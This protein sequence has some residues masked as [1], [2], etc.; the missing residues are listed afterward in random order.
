MST[1]LS[2]STP[3]I[4]LE[5]DELLFAIPGAPNENSGRFHAR[6]ALWWLVASFIRYWWIYHERSRPAS[7]GIAA[8]LVLFTLV[9]LVYTPWR[10]YLLSSEGMTPMEIPPW[11]AQLVYLIFMLMPFGA[12]L[13]DALSHATISDMLYVVWCAM[14]HHNAHS[15]TGFKSKAI[16]STGLA[17]G[18]YAI[19]YGHKALPRRSWLP[20]YQRAGLW[21][22]WITL[23]FAVW[24]REWLIAYVAWLMLFAC[25][26]WLHDN[27][28]GHVIAAFRTSYG[29]RSYDPDVTPQGHSLHYHLQSYGPPPITRHETRNVIPG[30]VIIDTIVSACPSLLP[31]LVR[32]VYDYSWCRS[33]A[34]LDLLC[35]DIPLRLSCDAWFNI[36]QLNVYRIH[37]AVSTPDCIE[38]AWYLRAP[39]QLGGYCHVPLIQIPVRYIPPKA[40]A[41]AIPLPYRQVDPFDR[42]A[43][44]HYI[45]DTFSSDICQHQRQHIVTSWTQLQS[46]D[47]YLRLTY[48]SMMTHGIPTPPPCSQSMSFHEQLRE[49]VRRTYDKVMDRSPLLASICHGIYDQ[50]FGPREGSS[51]RPLIPLTP[52]S[53]A[54]AVSSLSSL[55]SPCHYTAGIRMRQNSSDDLSSQ[56]SRS[57]SSSSLSLSWSPP[58]SPPSLSPSSS[59]SSLSSSM[60]EPSCSSSSSGSSSITRSRSSSQSM[61]I[62]EIPVHDIQAPPPGIRALRLNLVVRIHLKWDL[63]TTQ[64]MLPEYHF[65]WVEPAIHV[66]CAA[67]ASLASSSSPLAAA[68]APESAS[69]L[70]SSSSSSASL[71]LPSSYRHSAYNVSNSRWMRVD[72]DDYEHRQHHNDDEYAH[73]HDDDHQHE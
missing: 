9:N 42:V 12:S 32:L 70:P 39:L 71:A 46:I 29:H 45:L 10:D 19:T 62:I 55:S 49:R 57:L 41:A 22:P 54:A 21:M 64:A 20:R 6:Y 52:S 69:Q 13:G 7:H 1:P 17:V 60:G 40:G 25:V 50:A 5:I 33:G 66:P 63:Y 28:E 23:A 48:D 68:A 72:P 73:F 65:L 24:Q 44:G 11:I 67:C 58:P 51:G 38:D 53:A 31:E 3:N 15:L 36:R 18:F 2:S 59:S 56:L 43:R 61:R 34:P 27:N 4:T 30:R 35:D 26:Y 37:A 47:H 16:L 14:L 8:C